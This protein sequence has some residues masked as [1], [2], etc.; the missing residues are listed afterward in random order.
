MADVH[1]DNGN[2][3]GNDEDLKADTDGKVKQD[4]SNFDEHGNWIGIAEPDQ[5]TE[6][7]S[8]KVED[9]KDEPESVKSDKKDEKKK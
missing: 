3:I 2:F 8:P 6:K 9:K 5:K 1:D 7:A 4:P